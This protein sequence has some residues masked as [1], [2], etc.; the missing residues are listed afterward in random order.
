MPGR[1]WKDNVFETLL[2]QILC[3]YEC[4]G[5]QFDGLQINTGLNSTGFLGSSF[6][7]TTLAP[8]SLILFMKVSCIRKWRV[9]KITLSVAGCMAE[10]A[11]K[12]GVLLLIVIYFKLSCHH[13]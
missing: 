8:L 11:L 9:C 2:H 5:L 1:F 6:P 13:N 12:P 10:R 7:Y 3:I 4:V